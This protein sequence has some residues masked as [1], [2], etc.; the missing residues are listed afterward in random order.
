MSVRENKII[1]VLNIIVIIIGFDLVL[2]NPV[3][4]AASNV[5]LAFILIAISNIML[6]RK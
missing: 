6:N 4:D 3:L 2:R 5:G 1:L